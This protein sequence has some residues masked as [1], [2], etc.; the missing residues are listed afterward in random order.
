MEYFELTTFVIKE[1]CDGNYYHHIVLSLKN[2]SLKMFSLHTVV[3]FSPVGYN[4]MSPHH[5]VSPTKVRSPLYAGS[6]GPLQAHSPY[7]HATP[8]HSPPDQ[9][10]GPHQMASSP[11]QFAVQNHAASYSPYHGTAQGPHSSAGHLRGVF[12]CFYM[13]MLSSI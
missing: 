13:Y 2:C 12:D 6:P 8:Q 5:R 1:L 4:H 9:G 3:G 10:G 11:H 7:R